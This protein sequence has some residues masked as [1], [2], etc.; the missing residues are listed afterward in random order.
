[1]KNRFINLLFGLFSFSGFSQDVTRETIPVSSE[2]D[3]LEINIR[4]KSFE[5][6][7]QGIKELFEN[8]ADEAFLSFLSSSTHY[9]DKSLFDD[10][11]YMFFSRMNIPLM[12]LF[13]IGT[14]T[15]ADLNEIKSTL[16]QYSTYGGAKFGLGV[17]AWTQH[18]TLGAFKYFN[19]LPKSAS[20]DLIK[21]YISDPTL[22][23]AINKT[24]AMDYLNVASEEGNNSAL[25]GKARILLNEG[26]IKEAIYHLIPFI[27]D[28]LP[29]IMSGNQ[30][31]AAESK[32]IFADA[33][34]NNR[35]D[36][37]D[38]IQRDYEKIYYA[39][40]RLIENKNKAN[41][42]ENYLKILEE[43]EKTVIY[44]MALIQKIYDIVKSAPKAEK[45]EDRLDEFDIQLNV[46]REYKKIMPT[47]FS[48][49]EKLFSVSSLQKQFEKDSLEAKKFYLDYTANDA[50]NNLKGVEN[51]TKDLITKDKVNEYEV[52]VVEGIVNNFKS[53]ISIAEKTPFS[54]GPTLSEL[55]TGKA[56]METELTRRKELLA[57]SIK[58]REDQRLKDLAK[59]RRYVLLAGIQLAPLVPMPEVDYIG[60]LDFRKR[61]HAHSFEYGMLFGKIA[62]A[63]RV[64]WKG[65]QFGYAYKKMMRNNVLYWSLSATYSQRNYFAATYKAAIPD[66]ALSLIPTDVSNL[67][68]QR[69][70]VCINIGKQGVGKVLFY[71]WYIGIGVAQNAFTASRNG[72]NVI[73]SAASPSTFEDLASYNKR[74]QDK[75]YGAYF[76]AGLS[77]GITNNWK[78]Y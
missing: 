46:L 38:F 65:Q 43:E 58:D 37:S 19:A 45:P 68:N 3:A 56:K 32:L 54:E 20:F 31:M 25:Y 2:A 35:M 36:F 28:N 60:H 11:G 22:K 59:S 15:P 26:N 4:A 64:A 30:T 62:Y 50:R 52:L 75:F 18:D 29:V 7:N 14:T 66:S 10:A 63:N 78:R 17:I 13:N 1:M 61:G 21:T 76:R 71:D 24:I 34:L 6:F 47:D 5:E 40:Q 72:A 42:S 41:L 69:V 77:I 67:K 39:Y 44:R 27:V 73:Y 57:E 33:F 55:Q 9:W 74:V 70:G 51:I 48:G 12:K 8:K 53:F 23:S 16:E 49:N